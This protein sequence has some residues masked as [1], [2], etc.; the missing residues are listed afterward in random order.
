MKATTVV[1]AQTKHNTQAY[2]MAPSPVSAADGPDTATTMAA[3]NTH[4]QALP[5]ALH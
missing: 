4:T 2:C 3:A 1:A 5:Q